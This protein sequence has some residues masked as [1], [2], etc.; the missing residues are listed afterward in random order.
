MSQRL[1]WPK[2]ILVAVDFDAT[3]ESALSHGRWWARQSGASLAVLH[4][5]AEPSSGAASG[6][7]T[8]LPELRGLVETAMPQDEPPPEL[9]LRAGRPGPEISAAAA[10]TGADLI[11][12]GTHGRGVVGRWTLGSVADD[13]L[14]TTAVPVLL[15]HVA[16]DFSRDGVVVA[17]VDLSD[18]SAAVVRHAGDLAAARA[19]PLRLLHV[20]PIG[21]HRSPGHV[22]MREAATGSLKELQE[23]HVPPAVEAEVHVAMRME[24]PASAIAQYAKSQ[25]AVLIVMGAHG[26]SGWTRGVLGSVTARLLHETALPVLVVR[27]AAHD[28][29]MT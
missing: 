1:Q 13:L 10:S 26:A 14:R 9:L 18:A 17:A 12:V 29:A 23:R 21:D 16:G 2:R 7:H 8:A 22:V 5:G 20:L 6:I 24:A 28:E 4:V 27:A 3:A 25:R 19:A 11:V 15:V